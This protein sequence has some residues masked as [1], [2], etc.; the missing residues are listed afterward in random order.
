MKTY[1]AIA[2]LEALNKI[3]AG[4]AKTPLKFAY[5]AA[6]DAGMH[7]PDGCCELLQFLAQ[8]FA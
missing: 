1:E 7:V 8:L 3:A 6:R 5:A 4:D 2:A